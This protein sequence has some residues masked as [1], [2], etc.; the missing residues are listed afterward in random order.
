[1]TELKGREMYILIAIDKDA[2]MCIPIRTL[3]I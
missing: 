2:K 3:S 1:M